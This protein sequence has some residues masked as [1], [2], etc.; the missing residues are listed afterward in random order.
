M[1]PGGILRITVTVREIHGE[2]AETVLFAL[3]YHIPVGMCRVV[4][5][6]GTHGIHGGVILCDKDV[7]EVTVNR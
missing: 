7:Q 3:E 2:L 5:C 1:L 4:A 6:H